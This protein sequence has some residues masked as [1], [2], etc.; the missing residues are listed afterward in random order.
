MKR[1]LRP[2]HERLEG[3]RLARLQLLDREVAFVQ[4]QAVRPENQVVR[5][6]LRVDPCPEIDAEVLDR[7]LRLRIDEA[8]GECLVG[9]VEVRL[10]QQRRELQRL[11]VVHEPVA[12]DGIGRQNLRDVVVEQ[13]QFAE[14]VAILRDGQPP[15]AAVL[16]RRPRTGHL[17]RLLHPLDRPLAF[18]GR[19]LLRVLRRHRS[20]RDL[21]QHVLPQ[22]EMAVFQLR[23]EVI[24]AD[25]GG[26][27]VRVVAAHAV[28]LEE[29]LHVLVERL[30]ERGRVVGP[31]RCRNEQQDD[32]EERLVCRKVMTSL[33]S[34]RQRAVR[35]RF[36]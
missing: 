36:G 26:H 6:R 35:R 7:R 32:E 3:E 9:D 20:G 1:I 27:L 11:L 19:R 24:D 30:L 2:H 8:A 18:V 10:E 14:R 23:I 5:D 21:L 25:A 34:G 13:E 16:R 28:L 12:G 22:L 31:G 29:R 33:E 17:H 4:Q 15:H